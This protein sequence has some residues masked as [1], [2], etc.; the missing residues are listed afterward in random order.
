SQ[1]RSTREPRRRRTTPEPGSVGRAGPFARRLSSSP[2]EEEVVDLLLRLGVEPYR[3]LCHEALPHNQ[4][5]DVG[6]PLFQGQ[7]GVVVGPCRN[8]IPADKLDREVDSLFVLG[9]SDELNLRA[10]R[11]DSRHPR[12]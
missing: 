7:N 3:L 8:V 2:P 10:I 6:L 1:W 12:A 4:R 9:G 11:A 5:L